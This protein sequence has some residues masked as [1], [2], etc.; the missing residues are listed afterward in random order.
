MLGLVRLEVFATEWKDSKIFSFLDA[1]GISL[2]IIFASPALSLSSIRIASAFPRGF[3][4]V[5]TSATNTLLLVCSTF[6]FSLCM[7]L[8]HMGRNER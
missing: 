5:F 7:L 6:A 4:N 8:R 2:I 1:L 3:A